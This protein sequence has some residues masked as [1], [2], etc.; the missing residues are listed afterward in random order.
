MLTIRVRVICWMN[1]FSTKL[2][3]QVRLQLNHDICDDI[4]FTVYL[5]V[6]SGLFAG[7]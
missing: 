3:F 1:E 2:S 5:I 7:V 6:V 4:I